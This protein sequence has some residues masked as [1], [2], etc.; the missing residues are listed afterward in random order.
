MKNQT[1]YIWIGTITLGGVLGY[2][3]YK[4]L[5][6]NSNVAKNESVDEVLD[7]TP[8]PALAKT[9]PFTAMLN[10]TFPAITFK[11]TDY[12]YKNPFADV[13]TAIAN[14]NPF[15]NSTSTNDRLV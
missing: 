13:N 5:N 4:T 10:K 1:T 12:S 7:T 8:T 11:P 6:K 14:V 3:I 9:N 2:F 15:N